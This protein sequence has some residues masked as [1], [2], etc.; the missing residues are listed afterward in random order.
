MDVDDFLQ[1][2]RALE[3]KE[4]LE[5]AKRKLKE[6]KSHLLEEQRK[7]KESRHPRPEVQDRSQGS[8]GSGLKPWMIWDLIILGV[9]LL[10]FITAMFFPSASFDSPAAQKVIDDRVTAK[11]AVL[12]AEIADLKANM[13]LKPVAKTVTPKKVVDTTDEETTLSNEVPRPLSDFKVQMQ[14]TDGNSA[15]EIEGNGSEIRY[16]FVI[17]NPGKKNHEVCKVDRVKDGEETKNYISNVFVKKGEKDETTYTVTD[18]GTTNFVY[19]VRCAFAEYNDA[20]KLEAISEFSL[21][22]EVKLKTILN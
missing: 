22:V 3:A 4:R 21:P 14:D 20:N 5:D 13:T 15:G 10:L 18:K 16:L 19:R 8:D 2:K 7:L 11:T 1:E 9:A 17:E 6:E 12:E